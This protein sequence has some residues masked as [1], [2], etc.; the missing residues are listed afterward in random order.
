MCQHRGGLVVRHHPPRGRSEPASTAAPPAADQT[1]RV[2]EELRGKAI[3]GVVR[4]LAGVSW[5]VARTW[6]R[7]GK[8]RVDGE[9]WVD[10][11]RRARTG[12]EISLHLRAP[13]P[14]VARVMALEADLFVYVDA[15]V[16]V[17]RKP[18]GMS[19]VPF[20]DE[21]EGELTLDQLVRGGARATGLRAGRAPLGVV[22]R[23][24]KG[25][26]GLIVFSRTV[27]AKQHL[28]QQLRKHTAL[29]RYVAIA[30][31]DV[32]KATV[33]SHLVA[34]RGDGLRGSVAE[35]RREGQLAVTHIEPLER[36]EGATLVSCRLETG[37]THQ[38]RVHLS[39]AGHPLVGEAVYVRRFAGALIPAPRPMLH[40][41]ELG[42]EHPTTERAMRFEDAPPPDFEAMVAKLRRR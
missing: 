15:A 2:P 20:G 16:A 40:A 36:L 26:S 24:D 21:P 32:R 5:E 3:D 37:R 29:R 25:T 17:V 11:L 34:D 41:I 22:Q 23:L 39:E 10:G 1:W 12:A 31:G 9:I 6:I 18:A 38:I 14:K 33:R 35:G 7:T 30:H 42:F 13:R 8:V 27:A 4:T 28:A 19:T